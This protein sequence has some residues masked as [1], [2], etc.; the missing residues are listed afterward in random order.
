MYNFLNNLSNIGLI[1]D[2]TGAMLM[3]FGAEKVSYTVIIHPNEE[4]KR[5]AK[6]AACKNRM[7][8]LGAVLLFIGFALQLAAN[9][10]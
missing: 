1:I 3:F 8:K 9:N 7:V 10:T 5:L 2:I 4:Y 6:E